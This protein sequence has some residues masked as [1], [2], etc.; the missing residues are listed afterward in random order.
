[1]SR[2][3][4]EKIVLEAD[5]GITFKASEGTNGELIIRAL[6]TNYTY[7][8]NYVK[9]PIPE[10]Y[11]HIHGDWNNGFVIERKSDGSQFVWIPVGYLNSDG[12]LDG[13]N[14][15]E[16][17]GRRNY[18][19]DTFSELNYC[20]PID[21]ILF[22]QIESVK[23]Y[24]GFYI[25]CYNISISSDGKP[26]SVKGATP[27]SKINFYSAHEMASAMED[28][29]DVKSHLTYGAEYDSVL[30]WFVRSG[31][32]T[33]EEITVDSSEWGNYLNNKNS[34]HSIAE[35][36]SK[37]IWS[38]NNIYDFAGN[39]EEWTQERNGHSSVV[40]RGGNYSY[41]GYTYPVSYREFADPDEEY[42][43]CGFRVV[44]YIK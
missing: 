41:S 39:I 10:G 17:F 34:S 18:N 42:I 8:D 20:E 24:G 27:C 21:H 29:E 19:D 7:S 6:N 16:K 38:A 5:K 23:K 32:K 28:N 2:N 30:A 36:G 4:Y 40:V 25:S 13:K 22:K 11:K 44:L 37:K 3:R 43:A 14:F 33:F 31:V 9:P 26:Q 15:T 35:T 1:M 12:T